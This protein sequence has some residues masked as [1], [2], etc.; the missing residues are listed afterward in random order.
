MQLKHTVVV[1]EVLCLAC[2][3]KFENTADRVRH[4]IGLHHACPWCNK[5]GYLG[6]GFWETI[7]FEGQ[8]TRINHIK[9]CAG[10]QGILFRQCQKCSE[11]FHH[12]RGD[13]KYEVKNQINLIS[14]EV[15]GMEL[16]SRLKQE[17]TCN[18]CPEPKKLGNDQAFKNHII[19]KHGKCPWCSVQFSNETK[20]FTELSWEKQRKGAAHL[21]A[22]AQVNKESLFA[23]DT[24]FGI[25][26]SYRTVHAQK[27]SKG[28]EVKLSKLNLETYHDKSASSFYSTVCPSLTSQ[29]SHVFSQNYYFR[30]N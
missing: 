30:Y 23:C 3:H 28:Q 20:P 26:V 14:N 25:R 11:L 15:L 29:N 16:V 21:I 2:D 27:S 5:L 13:N 7:D 4:I 24:C 1:P 22:C 18:E 8:K 10:R 9:Q 17:S 6:K 19:S 12:V